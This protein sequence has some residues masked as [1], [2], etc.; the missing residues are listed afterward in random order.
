MKT[1]LLM[2]K[3]FRSL[4]LL[5]ACTGILLPPALWA[6]GEAGRLYLKGD[7]GGNW[8]QDTS[9]REFFGVQT[10]GSKVKFDPG[11]RAGVHVGYNLTDWFAPEFEIGVLEN[12]IR[13]L[14]DATF[15]RADFANVP[16]LVNAKFQLPNPS[17]VAPYIGAGVG[18][19]AAIIDAHPIHFTDQNEEDVRVRGSDSD[20]VFAWQA[21]A[22]VRVRINDHMAVGLEYRYF[23]ADSPSWQV[24]D[25]RDFLGSNDTMSFGRIQTHAISAA[26]EFTF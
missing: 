8:T 18:G 24:E 9:E 16:F 10:A 3:T 14:P 7:I 21:F 23:A 13:S 19:S 12:R 5:A 15:F 4:A 2:K 1:E 11:F 25:R 26:F 6:Q 20:A 17:R 22:G